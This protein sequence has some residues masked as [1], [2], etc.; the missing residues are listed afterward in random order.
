MEI[1]FLTII[2]GATILLAIYIGK[3][4][5]PKQVE[6]EPEDIH[7]E[8]EIQ[9]EKET[10]AT[11]PKKKV[12]DKKTKEKVPTFQH[13]WLLTSLKGHSGRVVDMDIS[14]NGKHLASSGEVS[15]Y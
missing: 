8:E 7:E 11:K 15:Q 4:F 9:Q 6:A 3:I 12:A 14:P 5:K 13:P 10:P 2:L 1:I